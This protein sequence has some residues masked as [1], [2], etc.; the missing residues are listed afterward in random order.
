MRDTI[1]YVYIVKNKTLGLKYIG[2]R[3]A[4]GC[5]PKDL[6]VSYFTSSKHIKKLI[7]L[8][9]VDDFKIKVLKQFSN[10]YEAM[11]YENKLLRIAIKRDDYL[12]L[13]ANFIGDL[14]HDEFE[15]IQIKQK[16]VASFYGKLSHF[17]KSGLHSLSKEDKRQACSSG[18]IAARD[19]NSILKRGFYDPDV[20]SK[21]QKTLRELQVSAYY[22]PILRLKLAAMGGKISQFGKKKISQEEWIR[23]Q[24]ERGARGG[25]KNK[26]FRW[27]NDGIKSFKYTPKQQLLI[28]FEDFIKI[29]N[30]I[31]GRI[32]MSDS[33][34]RKWVNDGMK[35][36]FL[37]KEQIDLEKHVYGR[38]DD[39]EK[40]NGHKNKKNN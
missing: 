37:L 17:N 33:K 5:E 9:G 8:F 23:L 21:A 27:Y 19:V 12:N 31:V 40:F 4:K 18:G 32:D 39:K 29:N 2:L 1:P 11:Q 14:T 36:Y 38:L 13:H 10:N 20:I 15:F 28:P 3:Y 7:T 30:F 26:G 24:K 22:D 6:W 16:K 35:N 34:N 25:P